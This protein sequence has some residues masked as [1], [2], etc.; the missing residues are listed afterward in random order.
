VE[1]L[2]DRL[3][4]GIYELSPRATVRLVQFGVIGVEALGTKELALYYENNVDELM[5]INNTH[6]VLEKLPADRQ[7]DY[8]LSLSEAAKED[9]VNDYA[10]PENSLDAVA[11]LANLDPS[12]IHGVESLPLAEKI[13]KHVLIIPSMSVEPYILSGKYDKDVIIRSISVMT[14]GGNKKYAT[15]IAV[16]F[17][18]LVGDWDL[19]S[20]ILGKRVASYSDI[21]LSRT[22]VC[23]YAVKADNVEALR[24]FPLKSN[25]RPRSQKMLLYLL[26]RNAEKID[27]DK[28]TYDYRTILDLYPLFVDT[29]LIDKVE[30]ITI[31]KELAPKSQEIDEAFIQAVVEGALDSA[32]YLASIG[33]STVLGD[34]ANLVSIKDVPMLEY[35]LDIGVDI[36]II[37]GDG[38][39]V[40][41]E[42]VRRGG[43]HSYCELWEWQGRFERG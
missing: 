43:S 8:L 10:I 5:K 33:A 3:E 30:D 20:E 34:I 27:L 24:D 37:I 32:K 6:T 2:A 38:D 4:D 35:L 21:P 9:I 18:I 12:L 23:I 15:D 1:Y 22:E 19:A 40:T 7:L 36:N 16:T 11:T 14:F 26:S 25:L 29:V 13:D 31:V 17:L 41:S 42:L 28:C 39:E